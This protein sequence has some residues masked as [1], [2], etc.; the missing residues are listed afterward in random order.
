MDNILSVPFSPQHDHGY[1]LPACAQMGL[2]YLGISRT[3]KILARELG[4][5]EQYGVPAPNIMRL[6]SRTLD[7]IYAQNGDLLDIREWLDKA[8]PV[9][10]CVQAGELEHWRKQYAQHAVLL[11]GLDEKFVF[12]LD[13]AMNSSVLKVPVGEFMLAW[14]EMDNRYAVITRRN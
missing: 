6:R 13:P 7:V 4:L 1:C 11:V 10:A 9:I 5:I 3:Q 2:A 8:V 14:D 12:M